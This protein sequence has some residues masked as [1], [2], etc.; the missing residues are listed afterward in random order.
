M[1]PPI[2]TGTVIDNLAIATATVT[3]DV[4]VTAT[5]SATGNTCMTIGPFLVNGG[6]YGVIVDVPYLTIGTTN[7][8]V[9]LWLDGAFNQSLTGHMA[10]SIPRPGAM[11]FARLT[12]LSNANHTLVVKAFVDGGTGHFGANNGATGNA[13]NAVGFVLPLG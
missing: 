13:P 2:L 4:S 12:G 11:L 6:N 5:S 7:L 9:E 3:A 1:P 10:A 8:D